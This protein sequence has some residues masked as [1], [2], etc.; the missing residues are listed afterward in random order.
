MSLAP[1]WQPPHLHLVQEGSLAVEEASRCPVLPEEQKRPQSGQNQHQQEERDHHSD[2]SGTALRF[3]HLDD[4]HLLVPPLLGLLA[5]AAHP[6]SEH[7][8]GVAGLHLHVLVVELPIFVG[9]VEVCVCWEERIDEEIRRFKIQQQ[10]FF[11]YGQLKEINFP[12][13]KLTSEI[14]DSGINLGNFVWEN[15]HPSSL[16]MAALM[17]SGAPLHMLM[18]FG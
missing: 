18:G 16:M 12:N 9:F 10:L 13:I 15:L 11:G 14:F 3:I 7:R 5:V 17:L 2:R 6:V 8:L 1:L 4:D